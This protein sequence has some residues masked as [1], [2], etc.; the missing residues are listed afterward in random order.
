[1]ADEAKEFKE[2]YLIESKRIK[3]QIKENHQYIENIQGKKVEL[4]DND[5]NWKDIGTRAV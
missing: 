2:E 3:D 1:M 4:L 5:F